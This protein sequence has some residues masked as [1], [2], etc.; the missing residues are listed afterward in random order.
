MID[1]IYI[2]PLKTEFTK[3]HDKQAKQEKEDNITQ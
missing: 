1:F 3:C 2:A